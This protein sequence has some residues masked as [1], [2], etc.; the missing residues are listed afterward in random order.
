MQTLQKFIDLKHLLPPD[1]WL[2]KRDQHNPGELDDESI[3]FI[4]GDVEADSLDLDDQPG[5]IALFV[6]GHC[7]IKNIYCEETDGST[8]LIVKKNLVVDNMIVGGQEV[9]VCGDLTVTGLFWG[10]YNHGN[11]QV[12]GLMT[13]HV[14]ISTDYSFDVK[15][16]ETKN[17]VQVAHFLWDEGEDEYD[18]ERL[19][20]IFQPD[21]LIG[22]NELEDWASSWKDWIAS[23]NLMDRIKKGL[24][25]LLEHIEP[26]REE[27]IPFVFGSKTFNPANL[28]R[29][30]ES[31]VFQHTEML[32]Y[33][34]GDIFKRVLA[35]R[36][37]T[38]SEQVYLQKEGKSILIRYENGRLAVLCRESEQAA[39]YYYDPRRSEHATFAEMTQ[40]LWEALLEEWSE[41][42]YWYAQF[43]ETVTP[44]SLQKMLD[45]PVV[46]TRYSDYYND[47]GEVLYIN[48][49]QVEF[50]QADS[51]RT[52]RATIIKYKG[53]GHD[54][55]HYDLGET[56]VLLRDQAG[57]GY[58]SKTWQVGWGEVEK[59]RNAVRYY[60][61]LRS[62]ME[63]LPKE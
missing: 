2:V 9:Y 20:T 19:N 11:L 10:D 1:S 63:R 3:A 55:Y 23:W 12:E 59:Y 18:R 6:T 30:R 56:G 42:E 31:P 53:D 34:R 44:A 40:P 51:G 4:E 28:Q 26:V 49:G 37:T 41:I 17:R 25:V 32:E 57:D 43:Q 54:F 50:R 5:V 38:L 21:C 27:A 15:R 7:K 22:E 29:L 45:I 39:W 14:F 60:R 61:A 13:F 48:N 33:W 36:D 24:P 62:N 35:N 8:G 16:F 58:S 46:K 52:P 47:D